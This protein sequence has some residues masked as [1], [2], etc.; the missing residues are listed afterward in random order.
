MDSLN[1]ST[2]RSQRDT[3]N[4]EKGGLNG[5]GG[6]RTGLT[7]GKKRG[8]LL[9]SKYQKFGMLRASSERRLFVQAGVQHGNQEMREVGSAL[10]HLQP[11]DNA[12]IR[13]ILG[14]AALCNSQMLGQF[15]FDGLSATP[16]RAAAR[17]IGD[18]HAQGLASLDVIIRSQ[19]GVRENPHSRSRRSTIRVI[20][21]CRRTRQEPAKIHFQLRKPR[22]QSWIAVAPAKARRGNFRGIFHRRARWT[23]RSGGSF[24]FGNRRRR[25]AARRPEWPRFALPGGGMVSPSGRAVRVVAAPSTPMPRSPIGGGGPPLGRGL[26]LG[27]SFSWRGIRFSLLALWFRFSRFSS[28]AGGRFLRRL[29]Y[30]RGYFRGLGS[31]QPRGAFLRLRFP[32]GAAES[33]S[34]SEIPPARIGGIS[35][36]FKIPRQF[37]RNHR[38]ARFREQIRQLCRGVFSGTCSADSRGDL[39]PVGHTVKAF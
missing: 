18:G 31:A 30:C 34:C 14:D 29:G 9:G 22:S 5:A 15:R 20:Q 32:I 38:V 39:L 2:G 11:A 33:L 19:I 16:R 37:E 7:D 35:Y 27:C 3:A 36:R 17:H 1:R 25:I 28:V 12:M 24:L 13:Q 23:L 4:G 21:F 8:L 6:Q 26:R 10:V